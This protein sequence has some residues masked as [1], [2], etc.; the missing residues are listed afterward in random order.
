MVLVPSSKLI[1]LTCSLK[2]RKRRRNV[3]RHVERPLPRREDHG[4]IP[5]HDGESHAASFTPYP[6]QVEDKLRYG[7][8]H[9]EYAFRARKRI[10]GA[11]VGFEGMG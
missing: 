8:Q 9:V 10:N 7:G 5:M 6:R 2:H 4:A 1:V 3:Q 11:D